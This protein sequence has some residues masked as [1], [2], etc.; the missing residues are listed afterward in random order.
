MVECNDEAAM[1]TKSHSFSPSSRPRP[2]DGGCRKTS[3]PIFEFSVFREHAV[4]AL[5]WQGCM[6]VREAATDA[7]DPRYCR[8]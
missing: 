8:G 5:D 4:P 7:E 3:R 1:A 2:W 6:Q